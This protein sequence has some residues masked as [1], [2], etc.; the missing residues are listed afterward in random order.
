MKAIRIFF[1]TIMLML[2]I[3]SSALAYS[4]LRMRNDTGQTIKYLY[5]NH[6]ESKSWGPNRLNGY[7]YNGQIITVDVSN[8]RYW[9]L[10]IGFING[11]YITWNK[12]PVDTSRVYNVIINRESNGDYYLYYNGKW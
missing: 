2:M 3:S 4:S 10:Q 6:A 12:E 9:L 5:F 8:Y 11:Q 7:W 1:A